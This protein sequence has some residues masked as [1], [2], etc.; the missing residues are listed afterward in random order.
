MAGIATGVFK[1]LA[2]K[3]QT[4]VKTKAPAGAAGTARY[5]RR[6][7]STLNLTKASYQS[8]E[9]LESQQRRDVRHGVRA[10]AGS[11]SGELSVGGYQLPM[12]SVLRQVAQAV[13]TTGAQTNITAAQVLPNGGTFTRAAGSF[14]TDGFKIGDVVTHSGWTAPALANNAHNFIIVGLTATVM[15]VMAI[16][17]VPVVA[18][19]SGDGVTIVQAGKKTW[20][21]QSGQTRDYYTIEHWFGDIGQSEQFV[22]CVFTGFTASL[23]PTGMA[24]I[25]LPVMGLNMDTGQVEYFTAPAASPTGGILAAVNGALIINGQV[26]AV[27]TGLTIVVNGNYSAPGGVIGSNVDPDIFPGPIDVTGQITALFVD[28][29]MRDLFLNETESSLVV[30]LTANNNPNSPFTAFNMSRVKFNGSD[31]DDGTAG[32]TLTVPYVALENVNGGAALANLQTT[33]SVQDSAFA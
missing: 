28:A 17:G 20:I 14:L 15:T 25:E 31:K 24:T 21:P 30:A 6:V 10:V 26:A 3:K 32:L 23:P 18:K 12:E 22:D 16:D 33:L 4:A 19:A 27:V 9:I 8:G 2:I 11:I 29:V 13:A 5:M 1:K 7:T